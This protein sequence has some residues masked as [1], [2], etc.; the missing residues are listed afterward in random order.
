MSSVVVAPR[1]VTFSTAAESLSKLVSWVAD[2]EIK[3]EEV[4]IDF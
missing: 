4:K 2:L 3:V 1:F